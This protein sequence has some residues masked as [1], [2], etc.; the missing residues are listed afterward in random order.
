M[1]LR[2]SITHACIHIYCAY[3]SHILCIYCALYITYTVHIHHIYCALY[4]TYTVHYT[5]HILCI[6]HHI[7][8][9]LYITY[10]VHI[11]HI[12]ITYTVCICI[13]FH[14]ICLPCPCV[15][16]DVM[17]YPSLGHQRFLPQALCNWAPP[18]MTS[19]HPFSNVW[20]LN[21]RRQEIIS[22]SI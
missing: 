19:T 20:Q 13:H 15:K 9:A 17:S 2:N 4:I 5:S 11:H 21:T 16:V 12:Y 3:T 1:C 14:R 8:C 10:T 7:Y 22:T 18:T 6:I